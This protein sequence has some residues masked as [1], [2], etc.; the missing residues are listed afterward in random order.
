MACIIG[1]IG[2]AGWRTRYCKVAFYLMQLI[3]FAWERFN[4]LPLE[5]SKHT[6]KAH[7]QPSRLICKERCLSTRTSSI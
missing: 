5:G 6:R 4:R 3:C 1:I 7:A 2:K